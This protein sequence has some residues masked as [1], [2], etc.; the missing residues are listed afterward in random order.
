MQLSRLVISILFLKCIIDNLSVEGLNI[1]LLEQELTL[2]Q[3]LLQID[4]L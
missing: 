1:R 3:N 2:D 4:S